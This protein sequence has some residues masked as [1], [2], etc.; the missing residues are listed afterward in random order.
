MTQEPPKTKSNANVK[1]WVE[2]KKSFLL[3]KE[4][5]FPAPRHIPSLETVAQACRLFAI[6]AENVD[7]EALA[8]CIIIKLSRLQVVAIEGRSSLPIYHE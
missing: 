3:F 4:E 7:R 8:A 2:L 1:Q 5:D 6:I